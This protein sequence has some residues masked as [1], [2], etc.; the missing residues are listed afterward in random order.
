MRFDFNIYPEAREKLES[1]G[2]LD[3]IKKKKDKYD[4]PHVGSVS[5]SDIHGYLQEMKENEFFKTFPKSEKDEFNKKLNGIYKNPEKHTWKISR[6]DGESAEE[7]ELEDILLLSGW[8]ASNI[9]KPKEIWNY[10]K[11]GFDNLTNFVG[12]VG[13]AMNENRLDWK[14][15]YKWETSIPI[16]HFEES[17]SIRLENEI[18]GD[19][20][21]DLRVFQIDKTPYKVIDP[22]GNQVSYRPEFHSDRKGIFAYHSTEPGLMAAV[23]RWT[24]Q[25]EIKTE[26]LKEK[27]KGIIEYGKSLGQGGGT[28][29]EHFF[30]GMNDNPAFHFTC[31]D[32]PLP[33]LDEKNSTNGI[34]HHGVFTQGKS[35]YRA[36]TN[37]SN[38]LVF[39]LESDPEKNPVKDISARYMPSDADH[40]IKGLIYQSARGL[41]RTSA[42]TLLRMLE[43]KFSEKFDEDKKRYAL[44]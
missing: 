41:G 39:S 28:C 21:C 8:W 3:R 34:T 5:P 14:N 18:T 20:N 16:T 40:L 4:I 23:L 12:S 2:I 37:K 9:L 44:K 43:Y 13:A 26:S 6:F 30:G 42:G 33:V 25:C 10:K 35:H 36:Y 15:G 11:F 32:I 24:E 22:L 27:A 29:A 31:W 38:E 17:K 19:T 7:T 1:A